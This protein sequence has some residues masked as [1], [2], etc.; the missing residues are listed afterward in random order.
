MKAERDKRA[1]ISW[2]RASGRRR[3]C[4]AEGEKQAAILAGRGPQARP[5]SATPRRAS[6]W[7]RPR[8]RRRRCS[9]RRCAEGN[10]QA[11]NYFVAQKYLEALKAFATSPNQKMLILPMEATARPR[12]AGRHRRAG[13]RGFGRAG[14]R[15]ASEPARP[16]PWDRRGAMTLDSWHWLGLGGL[17]LLLEVL[18]PGFV[19]IW[20]ALAA[21]LT[22]ILLW[23]CRCW[24]GRSSC[25]RLPP[26]PCQRRRLVLAGAGGCRPG[27]TSRAEQSDA[28]AMSAPRRCW[29]RR[30]APA[31]AGCGSAMRTWPA[32]GPD[33]P[34]GSPGADRRRPR[35]RCCWWPRRTRARSVRATTG[36][37]SGRPSGYLRLA[38]PSK[39]RSRLLT[40][41]A[42]FAEAFVNPHHPALVLLPG[43]GAVP[44]VAPAPGGGRARLRGGPPDL[45]RT[46]T[47]PE[48]ALTIV[49]A[50]LALA[51]L[52]RADAASGHAGA[53][54]RLALHARHL[55]LVGLLGRRHPAPAASLDHGR[56]TGKPPERP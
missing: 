38:D 49:G 30:S 3:S 51:A 46:A 4:K 36:S 41:L 25:W 1:A 10:V 43:A 35:V 56:N 21:G 28:R 31:M 34:A 54:L 27:K 20:L 2:P 32:A 52:C 29:R 26:W 33:L 5:R 45:H 11:V 8:P 22:G 14:P 17:L 6:A 44:A 42:A 24:P 12:L 50:V 7:R 18:T 15:A 55:G 40:A 13:A 48:L 37:P 53:A 23:L 19:F 16:Q 39:P 47:T 9:P